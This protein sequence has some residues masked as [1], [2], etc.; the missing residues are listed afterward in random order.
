MHHEQELLELEEEE[1]QLSC[2]RQVKV[3]LVNILAS[4]HFGIKHIEIVGLAECDHNLRL[5]TAN[6]LLNII[7]HVDLV[8]VWVV[9]VHVGLLAHILEHLRF[10]DHRERISILVIRVLLQKVVVDVLYIIISIGMLQVLIQLELDHPDDRVSTFLLQVYFLGRLG[11]TAVVRG[12]QVSVVD[13]ELLYLLLR[14]PKIMYLTQS[15]HLR[16][17]HLIHHDGREYEGDDQDQEDDHE[18]F[19]E[20]ELLVVVAG[21]ADVGDACL[22]DGGWFCFGCH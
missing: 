20:L 13:H 6:L 9:Q 2:I 7:R 3:Q 4:L 16:L 21:V 14:Q 10:V 17:H 11:E 1:L 18:R 15:I 12:V 8:R 5:L 22:A 19:V